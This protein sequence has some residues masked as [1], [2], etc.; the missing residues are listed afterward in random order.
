MRKQAFLAGIC[1]IAALV[2]SGAL[3]AQE[4]APASSHERAARELFRLFGG[5]KAAEVGAEAM[6]GTIRE[7]EELASYEDVFRAWFR[8]V[9]AT[10]DFE[11]EMVA[12]YMGA[13]SEGE[14][15]E[16]TAFYKTPVGQKALAL[17][18]ELMKQGAEVGLRRV[19]EHA[20]E[21][22]EMLAQARKE[23]EG[24][25][26][27]GNGAAQKRTISD[28]RNVGTAMFSWLTDQAGAAAAGQ[29]QTEKP[30]PPVALK[31][32]S[33]ISFQELEKI[34]VPDYLA[35]LPETDG[36]GH[37]YEFYLNVEDP[38][39]QQ[40]M[41]IRSPGKDGKF[42]DSH[43]SVGPFTPDDFDQDIVWADGFFVRWPQAAN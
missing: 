6:L 19:N 41:M 38:L 34:L 15:R 25:T 42:S 22:E 8:K 14:L 24:E 29:S 32:Y 1:W 43:Y 5:E 21:L 30:A 9:F 35:K 31:D 2:L 12:L 26:P 27:V 10:E 20:A 40:V 39:A 36:W 16:I 17:V 33:P 13:F 18:P 11:S 23:R 4:P 3:P 37:P 28:I 7:N